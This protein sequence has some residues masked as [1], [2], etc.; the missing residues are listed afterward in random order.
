MIY[1]NLF[2]IDILDSTGENILSSFTKFI[3]FEVTYRINKFPTMILQLYSLQRLDIS[4]TDIILKI[5]YSDYF[6]NFNMGILEAKYLGSGLYEFTGVNL[7]YKFLA[8]NRTRFLSTNLISAFN[9]IGTS[10]ILNVDT[11]ITSNFYQINET[12]Y[13][14][15][16]YLISGVSDGIPLIVNDKSIELMNMKKKETTLS[17]TETGNIILRNKFLKSNISTTRYDDYVL[18]QGLDEILYVN[19]D[20][21]S[22]FYNNRLNNRQF[23]EGLSRISLLLVFEDTSPRKNV[24]DRVIIPGAYKSNLIYTI[25]NKVEKFT[26]LTINT[27]L[28]AGANEI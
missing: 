21:Q 2:S 24:G 17:S 12:D 15:L 25:I 1:N 26:E 7:P 11:K 5:K 8:Q 16:T 22:E 19:R 28:I 23:E 6:Y 3:S 10:Y 9:S 20:S 4:I 13:S 27:S 14:I 18:Y